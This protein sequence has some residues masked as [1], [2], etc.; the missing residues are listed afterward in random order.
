VDREVPV[1][2][3]ALAVARA[4]VP[5]DDPLLLNVMEDY[6]LALAG[7]GLLDSAA[8]INR[9]VLQGRERVFGP[10]HPDVSYAYYNRGQIFGLLDRSSEALEAYGRALEI[11][12]RTLGA[13]H[14]TVTYVLHSMAVELAESGDHLEAIRLEERALPVQRETFG[15]DHPNTLDSTRLLARLYARAGRDEDALRLLE[16]LAARGALDGETL[17]EEEYRGFGGDPRFQRLLEGVRLE[18][19]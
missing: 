15:E 5:Q 2:A 3:E 17:R 13:D 6:S 7:A 8:V 18:P 1:A 11:R 10:D 12:E 4:S 16:F 9:R 14:P 19:E